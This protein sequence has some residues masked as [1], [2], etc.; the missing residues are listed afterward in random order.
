MQIR[1]LVLLIVRF[2]RVLHAG[3]HWPGWTPIDPRNRVTEGHGLERV[4]Y[5][6]KL[7]G[8]TR[9]WESSTTRSP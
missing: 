2:S 1:T 3:S 4:S 8:V 5:F 6:P 7:Q 9:V